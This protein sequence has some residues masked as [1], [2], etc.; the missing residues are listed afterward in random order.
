MTRVIVVAAVSALGLAAGMILAVVAVP[1]SVVA[2]TVLAVIAVILLRRQTARLR[3]SGI[4]A[5]LATASL[6]FF[7]TMSL[8]V[9]P[10]DEKVPR[11]AYGAMPLQDLCV[12]LAKQHEV[13]VTAH[14]ASARRITIAFS[15]DRTMTKLQFLQKLAH[16]TGTELR[17]GYCGLGDYPGF[18]RLRRGGRQP[19]T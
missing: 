19:E 5:L 10:L 14:D 13:F 7:V 2:A 17:I 6:A 1:F 4:V 3:W 15:T 18:I 12:L 8:S 11:V 9:K 16:D